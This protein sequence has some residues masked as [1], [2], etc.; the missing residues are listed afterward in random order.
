MTSSAGSTTP[1]AERGS[2]RRVAFVTHGR[3]EQIGDGVARLEALTR[4][5][6]IELVVSPDEALRHD[7]DARG[8]RK[9]V[10]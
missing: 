8:D 3:L 2:V 1:W 10:V 9:S 4:D 7:L 5:A 6:G